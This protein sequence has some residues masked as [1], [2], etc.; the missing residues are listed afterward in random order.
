MKVSAIA[1]ACCVPSWCIVSSSVAKDESYAPFLLALAPTLVTRSDPKAAR[2]SDSPLAKLVTFLAEKQY[3]SAP[4]KAEPSK[5][6]RYFESDNAL[7]TLLA[8]AEKSEYVGDSADGAK[9]WEVS[10]PIAFPGM[11]ARSVTTMRI[12]VDGSKPELR[13]ASD[14]SRTVCENGPEWVRKL[15]ESIMGSTVSTTSNHVSARENADGSFSALCDIKLKVDIQYPGFM[16]LP[17]GA[18]EKSGSESLQ[19]LLDKD[20]PRAMAAFRDGYLGS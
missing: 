4:F 13:I 2:R 12:N 17:K 1:V 18:V 9:L 10:T 15:L 20:T 3:E 11:T 7:K 19:K 5:L 14:S 16:P 8:M 6:S